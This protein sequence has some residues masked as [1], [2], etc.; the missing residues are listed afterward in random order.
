MVLKRVA[1]PALQAFGI[2]SLS[3]TGIIG[4]RPSYSEPAQM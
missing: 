1:I 4:S 2:T 3:L